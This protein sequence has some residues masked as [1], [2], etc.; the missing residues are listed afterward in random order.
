MYRDLKARFGTVWQVDENGVKSDF[1]TD[2][3]YEALV[4]S[5]DEGYE[6]KNADVILPHRLVLDNEGA[7]YDGSK[8]EYDDLAS[9][10]T[11]PEL[12]EVKTPKADEYV[13]DPLAFVPEPKE[14]S[15]SEVGDNNILD[16]SFDLEVT[17][18]TEEV[19]T[20]ATLVSKAGYPLATRCFK[21]LDSEQSQN[22]D[23]Q[24]YY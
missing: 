5:I 22:F 21:G 11:N 6:F 7:T 1:Y 16:L 2:P 14:K 24:F 18:T 23:W 17:G 19:Y 4:D 8:V 9:T 12:W 20:R 3:P 15:I 13:E 10:M